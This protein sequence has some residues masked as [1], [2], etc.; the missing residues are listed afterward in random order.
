MQQPDARP[1]TNS[2]LIAVDANGADQGP[3]AVAEG[4]RALRACRVLLF[5]PA[6]QLGRAGPLAEI[7]DAPGHRSRPATSPCAPCARKPDAS[8]VQA[9]RAVGRGSRR[10][11]RL[12]PGSTGPTLAAATLVDQAHPRRLPARARGAAA[13]PGGPVL[14]L[15]AGA[16]VEVRP[17]HLVQFAYMGAGFMEAVLGVRAARGRPAVGGRGVGQG[18]ARTCSPRTSAWPRAT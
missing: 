4:V 11:A 12:A 10:R 6:A 1:T 5:G 17:E 15:D 14:L 7:V 3:A 16:S 9:A 2:A 8:I 18:H 13:V